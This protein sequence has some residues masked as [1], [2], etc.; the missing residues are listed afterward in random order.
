MRRPRFEAAVG[1]MPFPIGLIV[2]KEDPNRF[3]DLRFRNQPKE[4]EPV[5]CSTNVAHRGR[6]S[7]NPVHQKGR[8]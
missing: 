5:S 7:P 8:D 2:E 3:E 4:V 6:A 1:D